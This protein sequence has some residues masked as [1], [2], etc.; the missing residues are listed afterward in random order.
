MCWTHGQQAVYFVPIVGNVTA[1]F[2]TLPKAESRPCF[3]QAIQAWSD[4]ISEVK[5][6]LHK[7]H[8]PIRPFFPSC[9]HPIIF[10]LMLSLSSPYA[11]KHLDSRFP[12]VNMSMTT[13]TDGLGGMRMLWS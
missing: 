12:L 1:P 6:A 2:D 10:R 5:R 4:G 11:S 3:L 9:H 7:T 13:F 8:K